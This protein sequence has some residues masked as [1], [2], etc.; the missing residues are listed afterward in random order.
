[1]HGF[2]MRDLLKQLL[3]IWI[4]VSNTHHRVMLVNYFQFISLLSAVLYILLNRLLYRCNVH[5]FIIVKFGILP[6]RISP[7]YVSANDLTLF[8]PDL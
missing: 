8:N 5:L 7:N 2:V 1:M 4:Q 6:R 3:S